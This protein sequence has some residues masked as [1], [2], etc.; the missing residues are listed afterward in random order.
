MFEI[1]TEIIGTKN[2]TKNITKNNS[3]NGVINKIN[4][5]PKILIGLLL[6]IRIKVDITQIISE[7]NI[8]SL[9]V[10]L[11]TGFINTKLMINDN[12]Y[13]IS[14]LLLFLK[15]RQIVKVYSMYLFLSFL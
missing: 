8:R 12:Q 1:F 3:K 2:E 5:I 4:I 10:F 15:T 13:P 7:S 11:L 6:V 14:S 9:N